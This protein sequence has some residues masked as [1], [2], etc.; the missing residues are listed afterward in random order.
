MRPDPSQAHPP[1]AS[2]P[3]STALNPLGK[4]QDGYW[5]RVNYGTAQGWIGNGAVVASSGCAT[6]PVVTPTPAS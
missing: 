5:W 4:S 6:M 2:V 1:I 3:G